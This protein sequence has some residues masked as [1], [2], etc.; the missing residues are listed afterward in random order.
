MRTCS[1]ANGVVARDLG[2]FAV[3]DQV[4]ARIAD[5]RHGHAVVP[6][7]A[8]HDRGGHARGAPAPGHGCFEDLRIGLLHQARQQRRSAI[9]HPWLS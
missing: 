6:Q 9:P 7:R 3:A 5:V 2:R 8:S 4:A 1:L